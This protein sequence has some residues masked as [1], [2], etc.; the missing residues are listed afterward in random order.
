MTDAD[1]IKLDRSV[2]YHTVSGRVVYGGGGI[3]PDVFVPIDTTKATS[4]YIACNK[5]AM[6]MRFASK[7]F[8]RYS[9]TLSG[10]DDFEKLTGYLN[11]LDLGKQ[12]REFTSAEGL[13]PA[14]GE[15]LQ[16]ESYL[17]PQLNA[18]VGRY[19]KLGD[20]AFYRYYLDIDDVVKAA[21][22]ER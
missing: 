14:P 17:M 6:Q 10:I 13:K 15:W 21:L 16:T 2:E 19:S 8:D 18:L 22:T 9:A 20:E 7:M 11:S 12:F 1:S 4:Y 3:V 5:K